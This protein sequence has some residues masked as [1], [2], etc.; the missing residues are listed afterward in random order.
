MNSTMDSE[1]PTLDDGDVP[2]AGAPAPDEPEAVSSLRER[3]LR[4]LAD[5]ENARRRAER[6]RNEGWKAGV[7]ELTG[8]LIPGLDGLD[9]A[10]RVEPPDN[11]GGQ[12]FARAVRDG[13]R[14]ARRE[15]LDALEKIGVERLD[16]LGQPFDAAAHEA[17]ATRAD[18]TAPPG[19]V[20][21]VLQAGYRLPERLI[22]P[23]RV[24]V[25]A[26]P[27]DAPGPS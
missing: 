7:A 10:V 14:A 25:S 9:L 12:A 27:R 20:L 5:A 17:V 6:A 15:L 22:R 2:A 11:E 23:A 3:L 18:A 16:P 8:R 19:H 21:E 13:V 1:P 26:A 24:V 4:A